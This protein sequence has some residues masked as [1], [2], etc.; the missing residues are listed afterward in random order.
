M[1]VC[2]SPTGK[3]VSLKQLKPAVRAMLP[4]VSGI[5]IEYALRTAAQELLMNAEAITYTIFADTQKGVTGYPVRNGGCFVPSTVTLIKI[6]G[7]CYQPHA[8]NCDTTRT[9]P[10]FTQPDTTWVELDEAPTADCPNGIEMHVTGLVDPN[11]CDVPADIF[12]RYQRTIIQGALAFLFGMTEE[13]WYSSTRVAEYSDAFKKGID[14][15]TAT[16]QLR[17]FP[18]DGLHIGGG[19]LIL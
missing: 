12:Y 7:V 11:S 8:D 15:A 19:G 1:E 3:T 13:A 16:S 10:G 4:N 17:K 18:S 6:G 5:I 2:A 14:A 9:M